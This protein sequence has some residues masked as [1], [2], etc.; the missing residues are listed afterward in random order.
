[1]A[2][3]HR[4]EQ[5]ARLLEPIYKKQ[6]NKKP[7]CW[8]GTS[9][10]DVR[11]FPKDARLNL[12]GELQALERGDDPSN[13]KA[14]PQVG[15]GAYEIRIQ[16]GRDFRV[17]YVAKW[18]D[19]IYVLHAF[20]KKTRKTPPADLALASKRYKSAAELAKSREQSRKE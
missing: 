1:M 10:E 14:L 16:V 18:A 11:G 17:I 20:E 7:L 4:N 13:F 15:A 2:K 9:N 12:G 19:S 3:K 5:T 8:M 6:H